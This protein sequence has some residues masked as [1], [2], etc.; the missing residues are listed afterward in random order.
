M[1]FDAQNEVFAAKHSD[2]PCTSR[3]WWAAALKLV[4]H[5][6]SVPGIPVHDSLQGEAFVFVKHAYGES[7]TI[8]IEAQQPGTCMRWPATD[9]TNL[10]SEGCPMLSL[11]LRCCSGWLDQAVNRRVVGS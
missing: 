1:H 4:D 2:Q 5:F 11:G 6:L 8:Q 9:L 3:I 10:G 7:P